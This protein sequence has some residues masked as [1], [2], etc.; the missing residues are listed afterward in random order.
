[1]GDYS[2]RID[3][4]HSRATKYLARY[5]TS[6]RTYLMKQ[7]GLHHDW[8]SAADA[9]VC[10]SNREW[11]ELCGNSKKAGKGPRTRSKNVGRRISD[12]AGEHRLVRPSIL[13][14]YYYKYQYGISS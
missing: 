11:S 12:A 14:M 13:V 5:N 7:C 4:A 3:C 8:L 10:A 6:P 9:E 1:M 2:S